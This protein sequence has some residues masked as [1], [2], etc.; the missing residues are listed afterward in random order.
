VSST[1]N[2]QL[3]TVAE[4]LSAL[5]RLFHKHLMNLAEH[6]PELQMSR[7]HF[8]VLW[9]LSDMGVLP[10][11]VIAK[12]LS[13]SKPYMTALVDK[14]LSEGLVSRIPDPQD[15]RVINITLTDH[16]REF[17][18]EHKAFQET[19]I[20]EKIVELSGQ[21]LERLAGLARELKQLI[22]KLDSEV[23]Q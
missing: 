9:V 13:L 17:L 16:G 1:K 20:A 11:S 8:E 2:P 5:F 10:M 19:A 23:K 15:R 12:A 14:L 4:D 22:I 3:L 21:E 18:R 7:S 6:H